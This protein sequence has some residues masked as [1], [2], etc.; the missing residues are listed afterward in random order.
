MKT[1]GQDFRGDRGVGINGIV[2]LVQSRE[3]VEGR[4]SQKLPVWGG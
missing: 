2:D 3:K 4:P 1:G